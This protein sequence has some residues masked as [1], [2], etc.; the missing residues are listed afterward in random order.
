MNFDQ[1]MF[2]SKMFLF[3]KRPVPL[4]TLCKKLECFSTLNTFCPSLM[5]AGTAEAFTGGHL[6]MLHSKDRYHLPH[7]E[8]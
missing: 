1:L 7:P 4:T 3:S 6:F 2:L 8:M 5:F